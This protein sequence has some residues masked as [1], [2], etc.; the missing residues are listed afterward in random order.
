[1][2]DTLPD[3]GL[4][5]GKWKGRAP[6]CLSNASHHKPS[7][8]ERRGVFLS[9][10]GLVR[11]LGYTRVSTS[12]QDAQLQLAALIAA[13]LVGWSRATLYRHQQALAAQESTAK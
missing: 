12:D 8:R 4:G 2:P 10:D 1:M 6:S 9:Q 7:Q 11:Q 3:L 13:G 5:K